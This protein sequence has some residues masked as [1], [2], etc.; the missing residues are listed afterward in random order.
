LYVYGIG[1]KLLELM[2]SYL[3]NINFKVKVVWSFS[4]SGFISSGVPQGSI[5]SPLLFL[6]Y[7]NDLKDVVQNCVLYLYVDDSSLF[8]PVGPKW[9]FEHYQWIN[10]EWIDWRRGQNCGNWILMHPKVWKLFF[11]THV[12]GL[13]CIC[14]SMGASCQGKNLTNILVLCWMNV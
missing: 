7:I 10:S 8:Y 14:T 11:M 9:W 6:L 3:T 12:E 13:G 1:G 4:D 2:E 5:L